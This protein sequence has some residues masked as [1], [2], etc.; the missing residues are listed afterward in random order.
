[1]IK[2]L[3]CNVYSTRK[4]N[5]RF[6]IVGI[7]YF[8]CSIRHDTVLMFLF[9]SSHFTACCCSIELSPRLIQPIINSSVKVS[10]KNFSHFHFFTQPFNRNHLKLTLS[11][12]FNG[13]R[14]IW[15]QLMSLMMIII[16]RISLLKIIKQ[17]LVFILV[18]LTNES[19][20]VIT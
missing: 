9:T 2:N 3:N 14:L 11:L 13:S 8:V 7:K 5:I 20:E 6:D 17:K 4:F 10:W 19:L 18:I 16:D 15:S 1:M 12:Q